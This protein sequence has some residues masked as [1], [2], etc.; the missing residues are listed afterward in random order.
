MPIKLIL[1]KAFPN[2]IHDRS[3]DDKDLHYLLH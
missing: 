1:Y 3:K 2:C